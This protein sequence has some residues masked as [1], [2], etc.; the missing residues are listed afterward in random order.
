MPEPRAGAEPLAPGLPRSPQGRRSG[1]KTRK[2]Y[3][4]DSLKLGAGGRPGDVKGMGPKP[5]SPVNDQSPL[6]TPFWG[7]G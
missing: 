7:N 5:S 4:W 6:R 3:A 2:F 1:H